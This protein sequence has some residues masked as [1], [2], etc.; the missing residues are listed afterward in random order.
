[1]H[2]THPTVGSLVESDS[3]HDSDTPGSGGVRVGGREAVVAS[4]QAAAQSCS[5]LPPGTARKCSTRLPARTIS[6]SSETSSTIEPVSPTRPAVQP[7]NQVIVAG[8]DSL[9]GQMLACRAFQRRNHSLLFSS[10]PSMCAP[11]LASV[12]SVLTNEF[13]AAALLARDIVDVRA[14]DVPKAT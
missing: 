6:R 10:M 1:M 11:S 2:G 13:P 3:G 12:R 7:P 14:N 5:E 9:A 8:S 4:L